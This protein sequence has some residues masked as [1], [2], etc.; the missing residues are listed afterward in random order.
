LDLTSHLTPHTQV[1]SGIFFRPAPTHTLRSLWNYAHNNWGLI[2][3][4]WGLVNV[5]LGALLYTKKWV[6]PDD[7]SSILLRWVVPTSVVP[8]VLLVAEVVLQSLV[9]VR[10][11]RTVEQQPKVEIIGTCQEQKQQ[12][13]E[14]EVSPAGP[15][16]TEPCLDP[17]QLEDLGKR[18]SLAA[19]TIAVTPAHDCQP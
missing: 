5:Y 18:P 7:Q 11:A 4:P 8:G 2:I 12:E 3:V 17:Q 10:S 14:Q 19:V 13:E 15:G 16:G 1:I 9:R 6:S